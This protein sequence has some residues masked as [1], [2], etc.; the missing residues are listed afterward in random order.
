[1]RRIPWL[2]LL[3]LAAGF[4]AGLAYAWIVSPIRYVDTTPDTLRSDFKDQFRT[5]IAASYA[6]THNLERAKSGWNF[7]A[8]PI[9]FR[10]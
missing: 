10:S 8:M 5:A 4:G 2:S 3:L 6:A 1:M 7:W 9:P